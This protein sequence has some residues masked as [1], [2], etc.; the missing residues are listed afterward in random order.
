MSK[1]KLPQIYTLRCFFSSSNLLFLWHLLFLWLNDSSFF[2][3]PLIQKLENIQKNNIH[4]F[5]YALVTC[6]YSIY[7][8]SCRMLTNQH[9]L[10]QVRFLKEW[11]FY[12]LDSIAYNFIIVFLIYRI[13]WRTGQVQPW[14]HWFEFCQCHQKSNDCRNSNHGHR[15]GPTTVQLEENTTVLSDEFLSHW[16]HW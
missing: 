11:Y 16:F 10:S 12:Y 14:R 9:Y 8:K 1:N 4:F 7:F 6:I 2:F 13:E 3:I 15:L 5:D